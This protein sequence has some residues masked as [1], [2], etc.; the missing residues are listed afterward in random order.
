MAE[1]VCVWLSVKRLR[2]SQKYIQIFDSTYLR[3][4][5]CW[6]HFQ[7]KNEVVV[8]RSECVCVF[9][10]VILLRWFCCSCSSISLHRY[11]LYKYVVCCLRLKVKWN[12][13]CSVFSQLQLQ[14]YVVGLVW[15]GHPGFGAS[16]PP[17]QKEEEDAGNRGD[18]YSLRAKQELC[19]TI[20]TTQNDANLRSIAVWLVVGLWLVCLSCTVVYCICVCVCVCNGFY[21]KKKNILREF[22]KSIICT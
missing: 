19:L 16:A 8:I 3:D 9:V 1:S 21:C 11:L 10:R 13:V 18:V 5:R 22:D 15:F 17:S 12:H 7:R 6:R 4:Q 20:G 14:Q 2:C